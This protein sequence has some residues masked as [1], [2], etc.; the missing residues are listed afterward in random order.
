MEDNDDNSDG[1]P[2]PLPSQPASSSSPSPSPPPS[3]IDRLDLYIQDSRVG[4]YFRLQERNTRFSTEVSG[5][6]AA[7]LTLSY[8]TPTIASIIAETGA[9]CDLHAPDAIYEA[10]KQQVRRELIT[11]SALTSMLTSLAMGLFANLPFILAPGIGTSA[12]FTYSV[13]GVRGSGPVPFKTATTAVFLEG[14]IFLLLSVSGIRA[15]AVKKLPENIK[16]AMS[17]GIG[18]FLAFIGMQ[19][20]EGLG[21]VVGSTETLVTLGGCPVENRRALMMVGSANGGGA[22]YTCDGGRMQ[23]PTTWLGLVALL[24]MAALLEKGVRS[25]V[26][27]VM[28]AVSFLSWFRNT[29]F[30]IFPST[31]AGDAKFEQFKKVFAVEGMPHVAGQVEFNR[32]GDPLVWAALLTFLYTDI[33]D[34]TGSLYSMARQAKMVKK[35]EEKE[36]DDNNTSNINYT[37]RQK[38]S[39]EGEKMAFC[40]D[41]CG[42]MVA[43]LLGLSPAV[44][45]IESAVGIEVGARTG[46]A[47]ITGAFGFL[48]S[49]IF[50][51]ILSSVPPF[52][53]GAVLILVGTILMSHLAHI[54]WTNKRIAVPAFMTAVL[55][56]LTYSIAYGVIS[57]IGAW[58][59]LSVIFRVLDFIEK[60]GKGGGGKCCKTKPKEGKE[61][62]LVEMVVV[63]GTEEQ[64]QGQGQKHHEHGHGHVHRFDE[65]PLVMI[66]EVPPPS[67]LEED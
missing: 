46:I 67:A 10:C 42:A 24:L 62:G 32:V 21:L 54:E 38:E 64:E 59:G 20:S 33:L 53:T 14:V 27:L 18:L 37:R 45:F 36:E 8:I 3:L 25:A 55:M 40:V 39:F 11:S 29:P 66:A 19:A 17:G 12:Y 61:E 22:A 56:P 16:M 23:S 34:T 4:A 1:Q 58:V 26:G 31:E 30:T 51:P 47:A 52:A 9:T 35:E 49:L 60:L 15:W 63:G 7:F 6:F 28:L 48:L 65:S 2:L 44:V 41:A 5:G 43:G 13:V 57:G 50:N